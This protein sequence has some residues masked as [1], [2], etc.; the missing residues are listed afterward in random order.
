MLWPVQS[1]TWQYIRR[2]AIRP[3]CPAQFS[4]PIVVDTE[5]MADF[6]NDGNCNALAQSFLGIGQSQVRTPEDGDAIWHYGVVRGRAAPGEIDTLIQAQQGA[7]MACLLG[8]RWP[9][10]HYNGQVLY[11]LGELLRN[12]IEGRGDQLLKSFHRH[13]DRH[14]SQYGRECEIPLFRGAR[15]YLPRRSKTMKRLLLALALV[16]SAC[17][18]QQAE[19][20]GIGP[21]SLTTLV[22]AADGTVLAEWH[23]GEDRVLTTLDQVPQH[24]I[25]AVVSIEDE[26]FWTHAGVDAQAILRAAKANTEAGFVVQGGSTITQQYI[27]NTVLTSEVTLDRKME[28]AALALKLETTLNK[29][30][31]LERYLNTVYFGSGAYGI[32]TASANYFGKPVSLLTMDESALLAG[33]IQAPSAID[34]R[35]N[36]DGAL[37]RRQLVLEKMVELGYATYEE[38]AGANVQPLVL[39]PRPTS[40]LKTRYPYFVEELKSRLLDDPRLGETPTDRYNALF[41]G[42]LRIYTTLDPHAQ[43]IA[44]QAI[45]RIVPQDGPDAAIV[46]VEPAQRCGAGAGGG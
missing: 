4:K 35:L 45:D 8:P 5:M 41:K 17:T 34:P 13:I 18:L 25:D 26:R 31:I 9:I 46:A 1:P 27:K 33:L 29:E 19:D 30:E 15:G 44:E 11:P 24:M 22:Y 23:A 20:P 37:A 7:A 3:L 32:A 38:A 42:G 16:A 14:R 10:I 12:E 6:V 2:Q 36:P 39:A 40:N 43:T 28:E 21:H